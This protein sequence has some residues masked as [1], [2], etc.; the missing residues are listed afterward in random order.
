MPTMSSPPELRAVVMAR[1]KASQIASAKAAQH[2]A[3]AQEIAELT[4]R[5]AHLTETA[6]GLITKLGRDLQRRAELTSE[7]LREALD[8]RP[9]QA[10]ADGRRL[11][12]TIRLANQRHGQRM[13][14][15]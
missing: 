4:R 9:E 7:P 12:D 15:M 8:A 3:D 6:E 14:S 5:I 2:P 11:L 13:R 1:V 10:V